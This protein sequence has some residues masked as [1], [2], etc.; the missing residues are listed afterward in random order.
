MALDSNSVRQR[1]INGRDVRQ[2][3]FSGQKIAKDITPLA[4]VNIAGT[5]KQA[6]NERTGS[7]GFCVKHF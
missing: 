2:R 3:L 1:A 7:V 4:N 6:L 5:I